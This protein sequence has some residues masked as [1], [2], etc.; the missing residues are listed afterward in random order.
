MRIFILLLAVLTCMPASYG[1]EVISSYTKFRMAETDNRQTANDTLTLKSD[2]SKNAIRCY[3]LVED[4]ETI[5]RLIDEGS[6]INS[7]TDNIVTASVPVSAIE[8][9]SK[10]PGVERIEGGAPVSLSLD[11]ARSDT[12]ADEVQE[13]TGLDIGYDGSGVII[14]IIDS[15]LEYDHINFYDESGNLRIKRVWQQSDNT[16]TPPDGFTYGSEYTTQSEIEAIKYDTPTGTHATHVAGIAA[17][18]YKGSDYYGI[19]PNAEIV[20][21]AFSDDQTSITDGVSYIYSYAESVG[22]PVVINLSLSSFVGARDGTSFFDRVADELQGSGKLMVGAASNY[23]SRKMHMQGSFSSPTDTVKSFINGN[24]TLTNYDYIEAYGDAGSYLNVKVSLYDLSGNKEIKASPVIATTRYSE[25]K[26]TLTEGITGEINI[27]TE[28]EYFSNRPHV[29]IEKKINNVNS[30]YAI[31]L[32]FSGATGK[33]VHAWDY[34]EDFTSND[35][36]GWTDGDNTYTVSEVGGTGKRI[37]TA[38]AYCTKLFSQITLND[39]SP[40]SSHGP[41]LDG[42]TKPDITAPGNVVVSSYSDSPNI[43]NSSYYAPY[44]NAGGT[45]TANGRTY[46]YG[47]MAGTS[48]S[49]PAVTGALALWLQVRPDLTPEEAKEIIAETARED[50]YTGD[51]DMTGNTWGYGKIDILEGI[52]SCLKLNS[53]ETIQSDDTENIKLYYSKQS[54]SLK[55]LF[56]N[57]IDETILNIYDISGQEIREIHYGLSFAG[58]EYSEPLASLPQGTYIITC[59]TKTRQYQIKIIK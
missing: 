57:N 32:K 41:T 54:E 23:G 28:T 21:V 49:A 43:V 39:I 18:G 4:E 17:G 42:R 9:I 25:Y 6:E 11:V 53:T 7:I 45:V 2:N 29:F 36:T 52:R 48:M 46:Y 58:D 19:A 51:T 34:L 37:I 10:I 3:I 20:Y 26:L 24:Y 8:T 5:S 15:G 47:A 27:Y 13:G 50:E 56:L 16:G 33:S 1:K 55:I 59:R 38:G 35:K 14:G 40:T 22:K 12:K 31:A 30:G 44:L